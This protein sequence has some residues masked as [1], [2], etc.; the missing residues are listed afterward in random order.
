MGQVIVLHTP[1]IHCLIGNTPEYL[2]IE[3][4][5]MR[6]KKGKSMKI[7]QNNKYVIIYSN[8]LA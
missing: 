8:F 6:N 5:K 3:K 1:I 4:E 7:K 2:Q